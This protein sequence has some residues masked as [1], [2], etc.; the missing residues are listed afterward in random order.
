LGKC[1]VDRL[2]KISDL[3]GPETSC[4]PQWVDARPEQGL[5]DVDVPKAG[6]RFLVK[7]ERLDWCA[8]TGEPGR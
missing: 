1:V 3:V 7:K 8:P 6:H 5:I 2:A 4:G